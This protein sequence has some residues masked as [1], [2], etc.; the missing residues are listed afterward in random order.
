[1]EEIK[2]YPIHV[3]YMTKSLNNKYVSILIY[4]ELN[5]PYK[6]FNKELYLRLAKNPNKTFKSIKS[7]TIFE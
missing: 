3:G 4:D 5:Y 7:E 6:I 2:N 1:M